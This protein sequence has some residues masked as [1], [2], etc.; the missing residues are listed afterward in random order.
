[1]H[2]CDYEVALLHDLAHVELVLLVLLALLRNVGGVE[3]EEGAGGRLDVDLPP[4]AGD[5]ATPRSTSCT[6]PTTISP[7]CGTYLFLS[8]LTMISLLVVST[9]PITEANIWLPS[10]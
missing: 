7:I 1:V 6:L 4:L 5:L 10:L 2:F 3:G 9:V 8:G